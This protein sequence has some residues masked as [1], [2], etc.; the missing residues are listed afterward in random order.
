MTEQNSQ[1]KP[2]RPAR[3]PLPD[4]WSIGALVI[5]GIVAMPMV[6]V[7]W[8]ALTPVENIWPHMLATVLPR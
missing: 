7:V 4:L 8:I 6:A 5:A 1:I 3:L 2:R